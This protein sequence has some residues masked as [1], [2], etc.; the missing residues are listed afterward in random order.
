[1]H[2]QMSTVTKRSNAEYEADQWPAGKN[3]AAA[4]VAMAKRSMKQPKLPFGPKR[5]KSAGSEQHM[6]E[7]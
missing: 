4:G 7:A 2:P 5:S 3:D 1:M 6:L